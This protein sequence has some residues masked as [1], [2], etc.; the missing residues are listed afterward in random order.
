MRLS[1]VTDT[2]PPDVNGVANTLRR[3]QD[4]LRERGHEVE[5]IIPGDL[6][7]AALDHGGIAPEDSSAKLRLAALPLPG[8]KGLRI[9]LPARGALAKH[10][11]AWRPDVVYVATESLLGFS[12]IDAAGDV[13]A[14]VVSGYHTN[15]DQYLRN[16]HLPMLEDVANAY[17]RRLHNRTQATFA[18]SP[19][20]MARLLG[21]GFN[22]VRLLGRGVDAVRFDPARRCERLRASWGA[23]EHDTVALYVGRLA[24]EK[25]LSLAMRAF[26][27]MAGRETSVGGNLRAVL[28][29]DGPLRAELMANASRW[30][31]AGMRT[32]DDLAVHFASADI[33]IF[34]SLTET[35][36]NV[37]IEAMASGLVTV[38]YDYAAAALHLH[39]QANGLSA[40]VEDEPGFL[41]ACIA[42]LD[43]SRW[44]GWRREARHTAARLTWSSVVTGFENDLRDILM[45]KT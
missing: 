35:F 22:N 9:G 12:A 41:A 37:V 3:L 42:A 31:F 4:L 38:A 18:P 14:C 33:F 40:A 32:G 8:Y 15:F 1:I 45:S 44:P 2:F 36:G 19:D 17:L 26:E 27:A 7:D 20:A 16:Y 43:R 11:S 25:N 13:G 29:G 28:V 30:H 5:T 10:W 39:H 6:L 34:P 23:G 21:L 24:P